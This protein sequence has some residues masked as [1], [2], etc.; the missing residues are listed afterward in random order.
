MLSA[1]WFQV[2]LVFL[3]PWGPGAAAGIV[4]AKK[5]GLPVGVTIG[6]YVL[7]DVVTAFI[8]DPLVR[9]L[10]DRG[11]RSPVGRKILATVGR[12]GSITQVT[13]GRF[14]LPLGLFVFTFATDFF[15]AAIISAGLALSRVI[16]WV[17]IIAGDVL[18][19]LIIFLAS[20]GI[21]AFL[22]DDRILFVA[23]MVLGFALPPLIRRILPKPRAPASSPR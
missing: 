23:T 12:F 1:P 7:S 20:I 6:L 13:S 22:S 17:C 11:Q 18:W 10:H 5:D 14:G 3:L 2:F 19:F 16:A 8:L 4:L 15:T 21:A 9:L